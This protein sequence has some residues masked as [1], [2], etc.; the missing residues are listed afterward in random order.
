MTESKSQT[1]VWS[2][3]TECNGEITAELMFNDQIKIPI[4]SNHLSEHKKLIF[5]HSHNH[6]IEELLKMSLDERDKLFEET[7]KVF[8]DEELTQ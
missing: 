4:C 1:C 8:P 3:G 5:L 6:D 7:R 2:I